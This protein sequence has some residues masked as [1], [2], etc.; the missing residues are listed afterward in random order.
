MFKKSSFM[1][2][3]IV[4]MAMT[5]AFAGC[6]AKAKKAD[7]KSE[8][9]KSFL[10]FSGGPTGGTFRFFASGIS[11]Y[12][13]K[14]VDGVS[15]SNE[16]SEGSVENIRKVNSGAAHFGISYSGDT[17]LARNGR[18]TGDTK[19]YPN[20]RV[21]A[22]L[23]KAPAQLAVLKGGAIKSVNDLEGK[24]VDMGGPGSGAAAAAERYFTSVGLWDKV[25]SSNLGY[26]KAANA[27]KDGKLDAMWILAGYPTSALIELSNSKEI[28]LLDVASLGKE[29]GLFKNH[30][31]YT[32]MTIPAAD[33]KGKYKGIDSDTN[34][35]FDSA[36]WVANKD[37]DPDLVYNTMKAIFTKEGLAYLIS[38][39]KTAK[40]TTV[41]NGV[42]GVVTPL[43]KGAEKFWKE[44]GLKISDNIK[45][46]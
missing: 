21:V 38:L 9:K 43:H 18:L 29:K 13:T 16:S 46:N 44:N 17:Y 5:F 28:T 37:V 25:K 36:L 20:V 4:I 8:A 14:N 35:F 2:A 39:K 23:Y 33:L 11:Q 22:F 34:S 1:I 3:F 42:T 30:P 6:K 32:Q 27:I 41:K 7:G 10:K 26:T 19:K 24:R 12:T 31:Y 40:Q 45:S 15:L